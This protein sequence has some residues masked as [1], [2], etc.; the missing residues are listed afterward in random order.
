LDA[1]QFF[2]LRYEATHRSFLDDC[3]NGLSDEQTRARPHGVNS[4]AWLIWHVA[5]GEDVA[6]NRFVGNR[7]QVCDGDGWLDRLAVGRRDF[8]PGM[9][10][11]E[12]DDLNRRID[13]ETLR[14]YW[15]AVYRRTHE[16]VQ[17][18]V[19]ADLEPV[20]APER[21]RTVVRD[22]TVLVGPGLWVQEAWVRNRSRGW[23]L[24]QLALLH[25]YGHLFEAMVTRGLLGFPGR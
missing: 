22:E 11:D 3:L 9:T 8:G 6:V 2:A 15:D 21:V 20:V 25:P 14:G 23:F 18:L 19:S 12:V 10:S 16:V 24:Q 5:R 4:I 13:L 1:L 17:G 7:P